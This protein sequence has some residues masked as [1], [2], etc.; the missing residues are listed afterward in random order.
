MGFM[1]SSVSEAKQHLDPAFG[2]AQIIL[3]TFDALSNVDL[4][5]LGP[6]NGP[7]I[8]DLPFRSQRGS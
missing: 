4:S 2:G 3:A 8:F 1:C 6:S 5:E 7:L